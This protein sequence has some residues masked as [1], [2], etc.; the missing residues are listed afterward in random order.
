VDLRPKVLKKT[1]IC[2]F[3]P[4]E[5]KRKTGYS[6]ATTRHHPRPSGNIEQA[7]TNKSVEGLLKEVDSLAL[8]PSHR[9]IVGVDYGTTFTGT[10]FTP[11]L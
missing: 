5:I 10:Y 2:S 11:V 7:M 6:L 9:I 3:L 4:P 8:I 1:G